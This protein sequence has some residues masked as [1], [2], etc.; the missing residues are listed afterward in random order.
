M[1]PITGSSNVKGAIYN[2]REGILSVEFL[3][4]DIFHYKNVTSAQH[5]DLMSAA[6]PGTWVRENLVKKPIAHPATKAK[7]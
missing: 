1:T 5:R 2:P 7:K 4:G 6:S 3:S